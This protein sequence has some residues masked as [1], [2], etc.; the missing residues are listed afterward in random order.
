[1]HAIMRVTDA[2][3]ILLCS[4]DGNNVRAA[5]RWAKEQEVARCGG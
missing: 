3:S 4:D 1:L 2:K 5:L